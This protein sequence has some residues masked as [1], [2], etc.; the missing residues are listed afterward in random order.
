MMLLLEDEHKMVGR[1]G[2]APSI[3]FANGFTVRPIA[4]S[5]HHPKLG[6]LTYFF[7]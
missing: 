1:L 7:W 2:L 5:G 4:I 6:S 3:A